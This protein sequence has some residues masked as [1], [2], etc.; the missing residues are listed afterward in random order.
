MRGTFLFDSPAALSGWANLTFRTRLHRQEAVSLARASRFR[1]A[2]N[3]RTAQ[4]LDA[5]TVQERKALFGGKSADS[6]E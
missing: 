5:V 6:T 4:R 1:N 2:A 3:R